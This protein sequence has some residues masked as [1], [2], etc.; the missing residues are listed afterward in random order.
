MKEPILFCKYEIEKILNSVLRKENN[1]MNLVEKLGEKVMLTPQE[2]N[3][4]IYSAIQEG[5]PFFAGRFG[6]FEI[7]TVV[8]YLENNISDTSHLAG[9]L[10]SNAGFFPKEKQHMK[11]FAELYLESASQLDLVGRYWNGMEDYIIRA[12][13][14]GSEIT[15]MFFLEPWYPGVNQPW[16][17][18]LEGKKVLVVH[19]FEHSIRW[20]YDKYRTEL[21]NDSK[22]LPYFDLI[23]FRA[24]QT[25]AGMKDERFATWFEALDY[26]YNEIMKLDFDV[27][28]IGCG[29]YGFPL[30]AK[31]KKEGKI[32]IHMGG[33]LQILFGIKGS[34]WEK[35]PRFEYVKKL[36]NEKWIYPLDEDQVDGGNAIEGGCYWGGDVVKHE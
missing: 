31:L 1:Y 24:I 12:Y 36:F 28:L 8:K 4:Q 11:R 3:N 32:A 26:M 13:A 21:F 20:Q 5:K 35:K 29:A 23:T 34:R 19:P 17:A 30:A 25:I 16:T 18:A 33:V 14:T 15:S 7:A 2:A 22:I 9:C 27:A 6:G 10:C